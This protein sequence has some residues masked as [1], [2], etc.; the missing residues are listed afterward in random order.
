M[1]CT[2][3]GCENLISINIESLISISGDAYMRNSESLK[4]YAC[5]N[6]G[7]LEFFDNGLNEKLAEE[8]EIEKKYEKELT[9]LVQQ[10]EEMKNGA[11]KQLQEE[12]TCVESQLKSLDITIRQQ[13][14]LTQKAEALK[15]K[16]KQI[17]IEIYKIEKEIKT[18]ESK[19]AHELEKVRFQ[20]SRYNR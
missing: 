15:V 7:H 11:L 5:R 4:V 19:K 14:E 18:V 6:C 8:S 3:C 12:L 2:Q 10:Q 20:Y 16:I 13:Q 17:S 1:K 9:A